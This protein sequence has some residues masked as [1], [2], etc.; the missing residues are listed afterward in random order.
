MQ[1]GGYEEQNAQGYNNGVRF[2]E[3]PMETINDGT[4]WALAVG[5]LVVTKEKNNRWETFTIPHSKMV[6]KL[7][8]ESQYVVLPT[9]LKEDL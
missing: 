1:L 5:Q 8:L 3:K 7:S 4:D 9:A 6:A 2:Y